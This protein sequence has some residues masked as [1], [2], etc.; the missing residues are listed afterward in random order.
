MESILCPVSIMMSHLG[1]D[2]HFAGRN[3]AEIRKMCSSWSPDRLDG[4]GYP[5]HLC[6]P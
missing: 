5:I 2:L 6:I 3:G 1:Q 4:G